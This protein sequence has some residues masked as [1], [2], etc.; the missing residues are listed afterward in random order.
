VRREATGRQVTTGAY[1]E[2]NWTLGQV[3]LTAGARADY[4]T[5]SQARTS[6]RTVSTGVLSTTVY[7][8]RDGWEGSFRAGLLWRPVEAISLRAAGYTSFRLPTINELYRGF[9][10]FP[11]TTQ[12]NAALEPERLKGGEAGIDLNPLPGVR[13]SATAF[14][15][16]LDNAVANVTIATNTRQ[17]RNVDA[18]LAKGIELT[19]SVDL[20]SFDLSGSYAFNDSKVE[21]SGVGAPLN[22]KQPAQS[23]RHSASA[24]LGWRGPAQSRLAVTARYVGPQFEDDLQ[25]DRMPSA[26]TVDAFAKLPISAKVALIGR[27]ENLFDEDVITRKVGNSIDLGTPQTFWIGVQIGG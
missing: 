19:G 15:N 9:T 3:V 8:D 26:T 22:G 1:V 13:F 7:P 17:R 18:I 5:I 16:K 4:W 24:T 20:G 25:V 6:A 14:Y 21:A 27:V 12:A 11:V 10:V 23:P 2:D